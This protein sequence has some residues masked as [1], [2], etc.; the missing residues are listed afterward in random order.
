[1]K[2]TF[3]KITSALTAV[4]M[5]ISPAL[6]TV[7]VSAA[8]TGI[9]GDANQDG[10]ANI[11]DCA[12]IARMLATQKRSSLTKDADYNRDDKKN[13]RDAAELALDLSI[14]QVKT[15]NSASIVNGIEIGMTKN[16]VINVMGNNYSY[17]EQD[18]LDYSFNNTE[19]FEVNLPCEI[20]F[21]F[22]NGK[23]DSYGYL[24]GAKRSSADDFSFPYGKSEIDNA[25]NKVYEKMKYWYNDG[26]NE[27]V[28]GEIFSVSKEYYW[29][30][31]DYGVV[32]LANISGQDENGKQNN[33]I[34]I[35]CVNKN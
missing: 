12:Y 4:F 35:M 29:P 15:Y 21:E 24:I 14:Q 10:K 32:A 27:K 22:E 20:Y 28:L 31:T 19:R 3:K 30:N 6:I 1:M 17:N 16:Q 9:R 11:R 23:L 5:I 25:F 8:E 26:L 18:E 34:L 7:N 13:V 33:A 2:R